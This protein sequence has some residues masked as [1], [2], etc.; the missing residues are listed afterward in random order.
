MSTNLPTLG[1]YAGLVPA[2]VGITPQM[3]LNF[4]FYEFFRNIALP[5]PSQKDLDES[6]LTGK[7][8]KD[9]FVFATLKKGICGGAAGGL[10]KLLVYPLVSVSFVH[11]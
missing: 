6:K 10:S 1:F 11:V 2:M 8:N 7:S 4:A 3:G 9:S 5:E